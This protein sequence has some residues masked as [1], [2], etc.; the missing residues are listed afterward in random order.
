MEPS[1]LD[2]VITPDSLNELRDNGCINRQEYIKGM[3]MLR[4]IADWAKWTSIFCLILGSAL[5][6]SG[7]VFFFAYNWQD[8]HRFAKLGLLQGLV[9]SSLI[10]THYIGVQKLPGQLC[11]LSAS[12]L[13]GVCFAVYGQI[14]QTGADA[15]SFFT[16][17]TIA[18]IP[19]VLAARFAPLWILWM[20]LVNLS[21]WFLWD[22]VGRFRESLPY[23][24]LTLTLSLI[25]GLALA[26]CETRSQ[27]IALLQRRYLRPLFLLA[28]LVPLTSP[29]LGWISAFDSPRFPGTSVPL[30]AIVWAIVT[31]ALFV[32]YNFRRFE[33]SLLSFMLVD[34]SIV[35]IFGFGRLLVEHMDNDFIGVCFLMATLIIGISTGLLM[36][37]RRRIREENTKTEVAA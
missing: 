25:N 21:C 8:L 18:I 32:F 19:W 10:A 28:L 23:P 20:I 2:N 22:Q 27:Q 5:V 9:L 1:P 24:I 34:I 35:V 12:V 16:I 11:L 31:A 6:L 37:V 33:A 13:V 36:Y 4:P 29:A 3:Q 26:F 17:W 14:Y 7:V 15:F 30:A